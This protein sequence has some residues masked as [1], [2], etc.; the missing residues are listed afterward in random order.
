[1][2]EREKEHQGK[3]PRLQSSLKATSSRLSAQTTQLDDVPPVREELLKLV[4]EDEGA[5]AL[6]ESS[7]RR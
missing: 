7:L 1:M 3:K 5:D 2:G 4:E 6:D